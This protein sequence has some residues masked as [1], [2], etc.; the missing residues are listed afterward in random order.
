VLQKV[1]GV[2]GGVAAAAVWG[3]LRVRVAAAGTHPAT[4]PAMESQPWMHHEDLQVHYLLSGVNLAS[5]YIY[6]DYIIKLDHL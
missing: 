5:N 1:L 2:A 6:Y 3:A 4:P